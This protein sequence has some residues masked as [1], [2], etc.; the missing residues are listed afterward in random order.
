MPGVMQ[1]R[2]EPENT[3]L[4]ARRGLRAGTPAVP[5]TLPVALAG[6]AA[7]ASARIARAPLGGPVWTDN[8]AP[9][10]WLIDASIVRYAAHGG[11]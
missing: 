11:G 2:I 10:E 4:I 3:L 7:D 5:P 9:V 6:L 1:D 8:V